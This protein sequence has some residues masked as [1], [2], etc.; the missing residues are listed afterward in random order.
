MRVYDTCKAK[1]SLEKQC[2][3]KSKGKTPPDECCGKYPERFPYYSNYG[4]NE[5]CGNTVFEPNKGQCCIKNKL[6]IC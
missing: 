6:K 2:N 4:Q 1:I 5:C 3:W